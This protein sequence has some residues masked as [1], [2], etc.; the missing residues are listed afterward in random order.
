MA[1]A[2]KHKT[3]PSRQFDDMSDESDADPFESDEMD[4]RDLA[5]LGDFKEINKVLV[6]EAVRAWFTHPSGMHFPDPHE[7][8]L[9]IWPHF[10]EFLTDARHHLHE[11]GG[12]AH[13]IHYKGMYPLVYLSETTT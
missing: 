9:D 2:R 10:F 11:Q 8:G 4:V 1:K 13:P 3:S 12:R 6:V 7:R 5:S